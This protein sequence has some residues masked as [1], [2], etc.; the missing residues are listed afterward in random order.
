MKRNPLNYWKSVEILKE[1]EVT[2]EY[3]LIIVKRG[4]RK[5]YNLIKIYKQ[6]NVLLSLFFE[7][8]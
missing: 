4:R 2:K 8:Y 3:T 1:K 7:N 5:K 6:L